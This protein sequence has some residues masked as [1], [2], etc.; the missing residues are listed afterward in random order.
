MK[1]IILS[2]ILLIINFPIYAQTSPFI[3]TS[4]TGDSYSIVIGGA[5]IDGLGLESGDEIGVFTSA[6]LCVGAE[7]YNG[8]YNLGL[9]AWINNSQTPEVDGHASN[10]PG[11][12]GPDH[13]TWMY[14]GPIM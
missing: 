6:G 12:Q 11:N 3:F 4:K 2:L 10:T 7:V 5:T 9:T 1:R 14:P 13:C 8:I